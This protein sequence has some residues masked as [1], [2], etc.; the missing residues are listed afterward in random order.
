[1]TNLEKLRKIVKECQ[2]DKVG[3]CTVDLFSDTEGR[4]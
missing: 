2:C 1:M 4:Q 3:T